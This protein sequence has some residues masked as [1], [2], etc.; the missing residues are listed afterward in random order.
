MNKRAAIPYLKRKGTKKQYKEAMQKR[1]VK[2]FLNQKL[3]TQIHDSG[4]DYSRTREKDR[5]R[6][7][8]E[9]T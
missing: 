9:N 1:R 2:S 7:E 6:K 4:R 8:W 5:L 3:G